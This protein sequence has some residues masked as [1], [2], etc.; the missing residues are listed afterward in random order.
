MLRSEGFATRH[1]YEKETRLCLEF[2]TG[3]ED[4]SLPADPTHGK[5]KYKIA[6]VDSADQQRAVDRQAPT[7]E[8]SFEDVAGFFSKQEY[9][10]FVEAVRRNAKRYMKLFTDAADQLEVE[11]RSPRT[12]TE[13]FDEELNSFRLANLEKKE[14]PKPPEQIVHMLKRKL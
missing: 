1:D 6:L 12:E 14:G 8:V 11:R 2:L 9:A 5:K 10:S 13:E 3:F 4:P 7:V